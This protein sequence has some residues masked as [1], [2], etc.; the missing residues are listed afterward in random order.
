[1]TDPRMWKM[2]LVK[3]QFDAVTACPIE[4]RVQHSNGMVGGVL[5]GKVAGMA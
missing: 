4:P 3:I 5:M 2:R 1:M